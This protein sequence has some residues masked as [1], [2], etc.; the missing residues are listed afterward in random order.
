MELHPSNAFSLCG[1]SPISFPRVAQQP[2]ASA[3]V[4]VCVSASVWALGGEGSGG[5]VGGMA[6]ISDQ[7]RPPKKIK[8]SE[9]KHN[10]KNP[11]VIFHTPNTHR[12]L[13]PSPSLS[14]FLSGASFLSL[15]LN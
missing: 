12:P 6:A 7:D 9:P 14:V 3:Y 2:Q 15:P 1:A 11:G 5:G 4:C 10:N 8:E 13:R